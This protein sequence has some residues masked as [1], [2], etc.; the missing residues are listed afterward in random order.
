MM[1]IPFCQS[2]LDE[3][4]VVDEEVVLSKQ[5]EQRRLA[6]L[7]IDGVGVEIREP[8]N[9]DIDLESVESHSC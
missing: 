8:F 3:I 1:K 6:G 7:L 9:V 2:N 5:T 4:P